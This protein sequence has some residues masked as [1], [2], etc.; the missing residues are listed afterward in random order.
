MAFG[1]FILLHKNKCNNKAMIKI[2]I[3]NDAIWCLYVGGEEINVFLV[4]SDMS[5]VW[6]EKART[7]NAK[8]FMYIFVGHFL[9]PFD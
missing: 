9:K 6:N 7:K 4:H 8:W 5:P 2:M 1:I 3:D